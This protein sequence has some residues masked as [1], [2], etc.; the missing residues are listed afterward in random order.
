MTVT[1][2]RKRIR[3]E[4]GIRHMR[5]RLTIGQWTTWLLGHSDSRVSN[6][7]YAMRYGKSTG[8]LPNW[9]PGRNGG[10]YFI[11]GTNLMTNGQMADMI[12]NAA[13]KQ[14]D[15]STAEA[16]KALQAEFGIVTR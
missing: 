10:H 3:Q 9:M 5:D 11:A 6:I 8:R 15:L 1:E 12:G 13:I 4:S 2:M 14:A 7:G 16:L